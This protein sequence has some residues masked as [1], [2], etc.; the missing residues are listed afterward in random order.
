M[1]MRNNGKQ[2]QQRSVVVV[3]RRER[4]FRGGGV[5]TGGGTKSE[6]TNDWYILHFDQRWCE[7]GREDGEGGRR[8]EAQQEWAGNQQ[9]P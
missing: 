2:Q 7:W 9:L 8:E 5:T 1:W 6:H 4:R 3:V